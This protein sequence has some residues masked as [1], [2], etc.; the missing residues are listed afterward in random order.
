MGRL[1]SFETAGDAFI[2]LE[3]VLQAAWKQSRESGSSYH[4]ENHG[5]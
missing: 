5:I 2:Q 3:F 1:I 4:S